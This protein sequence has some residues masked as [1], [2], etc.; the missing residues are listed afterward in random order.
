MRNRPY[1]M[2]LGVESKCSSMVEVRP[3]LP[4][5]WL[6]TSPV[7]L[8]SEQVLIGT[9]GTHASKMDELYKRRTVPDLE[10]DSL[11]HERTIFEDELQILL[12]TTSLY[13][14]YSLHFSHSRTRS[15]VKL[16]LNTPSQHL[17]ISTEALE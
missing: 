6:R 12:Q 9:V 13:S 2:R 17:P 5:L 11:L 7:K 14:V 15:D 4:L 10:D 8:A 1:N 16:L 3:R